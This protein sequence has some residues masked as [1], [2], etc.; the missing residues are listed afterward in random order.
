MLGRERVR[1]QGGVSN[2]SPGIGILIMSIGE[3]S[4]LLHKELESALAKTIFITV[5]QIGSKSINGDL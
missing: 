5:D 2:D 1:G 3:M 4:A